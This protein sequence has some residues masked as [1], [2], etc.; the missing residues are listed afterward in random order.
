MNKVC[1][2]EWKGNPAYYCTS[3]VRCKKC[4]IDYWPSI[5]KNRVEGY[6]Y[7]LELEKETKRRSYNE[8]RKRRCCS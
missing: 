7:K 8:E 2:H 4:G 1:D 3:F 5:D 6:H